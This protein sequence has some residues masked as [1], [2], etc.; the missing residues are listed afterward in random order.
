MSSVFHSGLPVHHDSVRKT[1]FAVTA[2]SVTSYPVTLSYVHTS[3]EQLPYKDEKPVYCCTQFTVPVMST[4][5]VAGQCLNSLSHGTSLCFSAGT[6]PS[7]VSSTECKSESSDVLSSVFCPTI[8]DVR[9]I[10][11][12]ADGVDVMPVSASVASFS[13]IQPGCDQML[14]LTATDLQRNDAPSCHSN[15]VTSQYSISSSLVSFASSS[16]SV[17]ANAASAGNI[18]SHCNAST[19]VK[20][21]CSCLKNNCLLCLL[22][23]ADSFPLPNYAQP[24]A[25]NTAES[26]GVR[27]TKFADSKVSKAENVGGC[28]LTV[29]DKAS[30]TV[31]NSS[32]DNT[33]APVTSDTDSR[34][35][36]SVKAANVDGLVRRKHEPSVRKQKS[37]TTNCHNAGTSQ[38]RKHRKLSSVIPNMESQ[39]RKYDQTAAKTGMIV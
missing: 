2:P 18:I 10:K 36:R 4:A 32:V 27:S 6:V 15:C 34:K 8:V 16:P 7:L 39:K 14:K 21:E 1:E 38:S 37:D 35:C 24:S 28:G 12:E 25:R 5:V 11:M 20:Q 23:V 30:K 9:S 3:K 19:A 29:V 33:S 13:S 26:F 31:S 22:T 17:T